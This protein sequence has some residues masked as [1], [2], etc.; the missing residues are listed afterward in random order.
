[1]VAVYW[2]L[3]VL[4]VAR[5]SP[6][7]TKGTVSKHKFHQ[8]GKEV[9]ATL[10]LFLFFI[11]IFDLGSKVLPLDNKRKTWFFF[12]FCLLIRTFDF[13]EVTFARKISNKFGFSLAYSYLC[14]VNI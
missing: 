1:M 9:R 11:A 3:V 14:R 12:V 10:L 4:K 13:V 5:S 2:L 7:Q 6:F 8:I